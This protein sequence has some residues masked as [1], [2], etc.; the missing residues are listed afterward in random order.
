[1]GSITTP[2]LSQ[3]AAHLLVAAFAAFGTFAA[4][5]AVTAVTAVAAVAAVMAVTADVALAQLAAHAHASGDR[6]S[7][8][9][10]TTPLAG[11]T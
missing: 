8:F 6:G 1:M 10:L 11:Y 3:G 4:V 5:T 2:P 7:A 9:E